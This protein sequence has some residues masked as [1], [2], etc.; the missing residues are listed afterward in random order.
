MGYLI[1]PQEWEAEIG[2]RVTGGRGEGQ[3]ERLL[4]RFWKIFSADNIFKV[5]EK[6]KVSF[7]FS[8]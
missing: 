4:S 5:S 1:Y 6:F 2:V 3:L 7:Y 8:V